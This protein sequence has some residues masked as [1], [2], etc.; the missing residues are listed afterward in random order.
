MNQQF[1]F[2]F[3][4]CE[5]NQ[6]ITESPVQVWLE[7]KYYHYHKYVTLQS[8]LIMMEATEVL[9]WIILIRMSVIAVAMIAMIIM[10]LE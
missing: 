2:H 8:Y 1:N 3:K 7:S 10:L 6:F 5:I 4:E 9:G